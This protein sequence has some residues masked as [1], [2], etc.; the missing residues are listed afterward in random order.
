MKYFDDDRPNVIAF[1]SFKGGV[2]KTSLA[3][4]T[5][6]ELAKRYPGKVLVID[7][8]PNNNLTDYFLSEEDPHKIL[9]AYS[10]HVISGKLPLEK[11]V[12]KTNIIEG[13]DVVPATPLLMK[14]GLEYGNDPMAL[15][16]LSSEI[17]RSNYEWVIIDTPP[18]LAFEFRVSLYSAQLF[19][20]PLLPKRWSFQAYDMLFSEIEKIK[21]NKVIVLPNQYVLG[22]PSL[23]SEKG[24]NVLL[25]IEG[26]NYSQTY[27]PNNAS[28]SNVFENYKTLKENSK[29][30][31]I[32]KSFVNEIC[33]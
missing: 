19:V 10:Y 8:D 12:Y 14:I 27:I 20:I 4:L 6:V 33:E 15:L 24:Y 7:T 1:A 2:G 21:R 28:I 29:A 11:C 9:G 16:N 30:D 18:S 32:I 5:A 26:V 22:V 23:V 13:L 3:S 31:L 25:N 17:N